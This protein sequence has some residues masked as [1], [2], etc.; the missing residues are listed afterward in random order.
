MTITRRQLLQWTA[1]LSVA[2]SV[3]VGINVSS[4]WNTEP[5]H[6]Y[7][8]LN[9]IESAVVNSVSGAAFPT[10]NTIEL[11]GEDAG[12][13]RFFDELLSSMSSENKSL[14]KLLLEAI[15]RATLPTHGTYFTDLSLRERQ[16]CIQQWLD[17]PSHLIRGAIQSLIVL[18]GMGYTA[19]PVASTHLSQYFRCGFGT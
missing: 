8:N 12:L 13:D 4:W 15:D 5:E 17:H 18:L 2:S 9:L 16:H 19:H 3:A 6:P 1:A 11:N 10:G 14:L 7:E